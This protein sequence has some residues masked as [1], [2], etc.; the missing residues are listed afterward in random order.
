MTRIEKIRQMTDAE[1]ADFL[2]T[3]AGWNGHEDILEDVHT[4]RDMTDSELAGYLSD[5][6]DA[7]HLQICTGACPNDDDTCKS[8]CAVCVRNWLREE[9]PLY[10]R[11]GV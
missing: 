3:V 4:V 5:L 2:S 7:D 10:G 1:L 9:G 8:P 11:G 6:D